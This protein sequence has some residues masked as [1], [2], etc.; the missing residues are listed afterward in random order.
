MS[1]QDST[2]M[3]LPNEQFPLF[4]LPENIKSY[5]FELLI[6][7]SRLYDMS[8]IPRIKVIQIITHFSKLFKLS[9][10][11]LQNCLQQKLQA[12]SVSSENLQFIPNTIKQLL[13][14]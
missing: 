6:F 5:E 7:F 9:F 14:L 13:C 3:Q 10:D 4:N 2:M 8:E 12:E 11:I 1:N